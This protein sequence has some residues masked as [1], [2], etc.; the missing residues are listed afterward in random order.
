M[1]VFIPRQ[2]ESTRL[3]PSTNFCDEQSDFFVLMNENYAPKRKLIAT[4][5]QLSA[6]YAILLNQSNVL[7]FKFNNV[8]CCFATKHKIYKVFTVTCV[9]VFA[10]MKQSSCTI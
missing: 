2:P 4:F 10:Q 9:N 5:L 8:S 6:N 7:A 1:S 3:G